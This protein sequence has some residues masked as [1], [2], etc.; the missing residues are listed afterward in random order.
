[1]NPDFR[2]KFNYNQFTNITHVIYMQDENNTYS[3][4]GGGG[5]R[6]Q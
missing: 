2:F 1:M 3:G 5:T 4:V 6:K